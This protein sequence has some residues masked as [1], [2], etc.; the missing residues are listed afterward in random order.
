MS[1]VQVFTFAIDTTKKSHTKSDPRKT[2]E[3]PKSQEVKISICVRTRPI[4]HFLQGAN[5]ESPFFEKA[6]QREDNL[7]PA[8]S[9]FYF[10]SNENIFL[11]FA[12]RQKYTK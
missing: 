11:P 1:R 9:R 7:W 12:A 6:Q 4:H 8:L 10:D 5:P 3:T 2:I